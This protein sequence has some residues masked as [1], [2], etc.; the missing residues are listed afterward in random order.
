[1]SAT[2]TDDFRD[3]LNDPATRAVIATVDEQGIPHLEEKQTVHLDAHGHIVVAEE[4]EYSRTNLNLVRS[5]WFDRKAVL[6]LLGAQRRF[7]V[8][9][10]PYKVHIS[11]PVFESYYRNAIAQPNSAGLSGVWILQPETV[12]EETGDVRAGR[13]NKGRLPLT[14][15]D[16]IA[17]KENGQA[18]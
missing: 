17:K 3:V 13:E 8:V 18:Q 9:L 10:R 16:R 4:G 15:L 14:H 5:L 11:G 7:E 2:I 1:M 6:H 12:T